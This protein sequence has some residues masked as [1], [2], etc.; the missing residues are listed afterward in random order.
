MEVIEFLIDIV[1]SFVCAVIVVCVHEY[2]RIICYKYLVHP[3]YKKETKVSFNPI[4]YM[5][6]FGII[7]FVFLGVGWQKP[8]SFNTGRL[9]DKK[10]G[11]ISITLIGLLCNL[12]MMTIMIPIYFAVRGQNGYLDGFISSLMVYNLAIVIVNVLP[13][14]PFDMV[15]I[16]QALN[17]QTYFKFVQYEKV[18]QAL[19]IL[20]LAAGVLSSITETVIN[21]I[22][23]AII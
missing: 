8:F 11:L 21:S 23:N 1:I 4:K 15:K 6:P 20:V 14:P 7:S 9:R 10:K 12:L 5:D 16:I 19:F 13:V 3:L 2:P 17:P 22:L 18:I